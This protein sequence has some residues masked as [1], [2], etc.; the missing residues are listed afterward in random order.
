M[1]YSRR[2]HSL[3]S[4]PSHTPLLTYSCTLLSVQIQNTLG[5]YTAA[6]STNPLP[7]SR[8]SCRLLRYDSANKRGRA[9]CFCPVCAPMRPEHCY[10]VPDTS[11]DG[12]LFRSISLFI[13][14]YLCFFVSLLARLRENGWT[15]LHEI[16]RKGVE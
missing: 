12:V 8:Y 16:F 4:L 7:S 13:C 11:G 5:A 1:Q 3:L 6:S 10:P 14:L 2:A 9:Y 15:N